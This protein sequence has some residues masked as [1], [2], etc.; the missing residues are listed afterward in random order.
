MRGE[1]RRHL[2]IVKYLGRESLR[3]H[4]V[5]SLVGKERERR[6]YGNGRYAIH[7]F[8]DIS[9]GGDLRHAIKA[10]MLVWIEVNAL[11]ENG[12]VDKR[13]RQLGRWARH[14]LRSRRYRDWRGN[15]AGS[16]DE[17][18]YKMK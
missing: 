14:D 6:G 10:D 4:L 5:D 18:G 8:P 12:T 1:A 13:G 11:F 16:H 9:H 15:G 7:P 2:T 3:S 17:D